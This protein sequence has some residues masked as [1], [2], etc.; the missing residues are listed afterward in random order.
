MNETNDNFLQ[1]LKSS[2]LLQSTS[3]TRV[4]R[5]QVQNESKNLIKSIANTK[6]DELHQENDHEQSAHSHNNN[7]SGVGASL[8]LGFIF[9][10]VIDHFGGKYGHSHGTHQR[11]RKTFKYS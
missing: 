11:K 9:M 10:L 4:K 6:L 7:H 3:S 8:V 5:Q 1:V 2:N